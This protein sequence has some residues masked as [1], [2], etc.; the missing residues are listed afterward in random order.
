MRLCVIM[1]ALYKGELHSGTAMT[2]LYVD[3]LSRYCS[4]AITLLMCSVGTVAQPS[5]SCM[6][7]CSV[8]T[9]AQ[10]SHSCMLMCSV[11]TVAQPT[12][13]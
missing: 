9:V 4:T 8:G 5:H 12:H 7:M 10:P 2:S 6:L 11:G 3:F 13:C 1:C